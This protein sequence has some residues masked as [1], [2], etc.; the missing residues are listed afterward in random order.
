MSS[1]TV[2][3]YNSA[4]RPGVSPFFTVYSSGGTGV[5]VPVV[6]AVAR[7]VA[8][9]RTI[10]RVGV[11]VTVGVKAAIADWRVLCTMMATN[12]TMTMAVK[13]MTMMRVGRCAASTRCSRAIAL[14]WAASA[15]AMATRSAP[16]FMHVLARDEMVAPHF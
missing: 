4:M 10:E 6:V 1:G 13:A 16:Q 8:V 14:A 2:R 9:G 12:S 3:S 11:R 7:G 15:L 5:G